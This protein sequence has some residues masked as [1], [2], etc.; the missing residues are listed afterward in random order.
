[1]ILD[2]GRIAVVVGGSSRVVLCSMLKR[3]AYPSAA[4]ISMPT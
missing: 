1:M 3:F 4:L 2:H